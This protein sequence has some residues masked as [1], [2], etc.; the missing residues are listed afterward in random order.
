MILL[1]MFVQ[2]EA[3]KN[4]VAMIGM[5]FLFFTRIS[6]FLATGLRL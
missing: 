6:L 4:R 3:L 1:K 2:Y 5:S